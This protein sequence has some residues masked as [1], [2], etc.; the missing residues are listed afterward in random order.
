MLRQLQYI[1]VLFTSK[2]D[3]GMFYQKN[4]VENP[5]KK[6]RGEPSKRIQ[7]RTQQKNPVENPEKVGGGLILVIC[8]CLT[9]FL[10]DT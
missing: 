6:S 9:M 8:R 5:A 2:D 3:S 1:D 10:R 4:P 7:W